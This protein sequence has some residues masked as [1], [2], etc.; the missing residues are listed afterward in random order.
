MVKRS[1]YWPYR[2]RCDET[3]ALFFPIASGFELNVFK[4]AQNDS[5]KFLP[6]LRSNILYIDCTFDSGYGSFRFTFSGAI[7]KLQ[8]ISKIA[9]GDPKKI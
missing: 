9:V 6:V 5:G 8:S 7:F 4:E 2:Y 1:Q 3:F